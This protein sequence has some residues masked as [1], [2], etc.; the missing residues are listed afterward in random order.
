MNKSTFWKKLAK[1]FFSQRTTIIALLLFQI[2]FIISMI[3]GLMKYSPWAY[4]LLTALGLVLAVYI[5]NQDEN[6][7]YKLAWVIPLLAIPLFAT[8]A[9]FLLTNQYGT[10]RARRAHMEK[11]RSTKPYLRQSKRVL[12][13]IRVNDDNVYSLA[14]YLDE[15]G[16]YPT[17]DNS[18]VE[19]FCD[20]MEKFK[21]LVR[22]LRR[23][24]KFIFMEYFIVD[25]G[26]MW[27]GIEQI[28]I[29]K[30]NEGVDVRLMYDGMGSQQNLPMHYDRRLR[31][32]GIK[33]HVFNPFRPLLSSI[34][35]NRDHRKIC[36]VDGDIAFTG[37]INLADEYINRRMRFGY[38]KD[39]AV[40][41]TGDAVWNFTMMFLQMWEV[42]DGTPNDYELYRPSGT[43]LGH[44]AAGIV[45][46]FGDSPLD[47][48]N[49]GEMVYLD[50]I[51]NA[52]DYMYITTPYLIP[53]NELVTALEYA[54][55]KGADVRIITPGI[56]DKWYCRAIAWSYYRDLLELGVKIYEFNG[57]I[58]A[59]NFVADDDTA[60]VGTINLDYRS[61]YLHFECATYMHGTGCEKTVREDF[62]ETLKQSREITLLDCDKR[63]LFS[64]AVSAV[65]RMFAPLL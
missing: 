51:N 39:S 4:Y 58:H 25:P 64:C 26:E 57:F 55:K 15:Y 3:L 38:W 32:L 40:K 16:G 7:A 11:C 42:V 9:Y 47:T 62:E 28:L 5:V 19:Y 14:K 30:V 6:P 31:K 35:N 44:G 65:L 29:E 33:C 12:E 54:A 34:Q 41:V 52:N 23:A 59:K 1:I 37:G 61:L 46:P 45:C 27:N 36:V 22:E 24:K 56:P 60:V 18:S 8:V 17:Y 48:E 2:F 13:S 63:S 50:V 49:V 53:N 20:G 43:K 10:R 21:A